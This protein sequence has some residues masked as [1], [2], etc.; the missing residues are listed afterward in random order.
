FTYPQDIRR[1]M[2]TTNVIESLNFTLRKAVKTKGSFPKEDAAVKVLYLTPELSP[3]EPIVPLLH[4]AIANQLLT[5]L[6]Q[7]QHRL[8]Q[9]WLFLQQ[10]SIDC[11]QS[12]LRV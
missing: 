8:V 10:H 2:Y 4:E 9:R 12:S 5:T 1:A 3:A 11:C 7:L 6:E